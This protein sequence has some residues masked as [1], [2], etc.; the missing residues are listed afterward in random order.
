MLSNTF[1]TIVTNATAEIQF[2]RSVLTFEGVKSDAIFAYPPPLNVLA[3]LIMLPL[4]FTMTPRWFHKTN[5]A[6][7]RTFNA[8]LLLLISFLEGQSL[9]TDY[10]AKGF[11]SHK[12]ALTLGKKSNTL[13][14]WGFA[15]FSVHG[16]IQAVFDAEPPSDTPEEI[17]DTQTQ[18]P[19]DYRKPS[20]N[21]R[22]GGGQVISN[23]K[24]KENQDSGLMAKSLGTKQLREMMEEAVDGADTRR[25]LEE[26]ELRS[27]RIESLLVKLADKGAV[28]EEME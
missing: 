24:K 4:K 7:V 2:R 11:I 17:D 25:R 3:L 21:V 19:I 27:K 10:S 23:S 12:A 18:G 15:R 9:W 8:P 13:A 28:S 14:F 26:L 16:D 20:D 22:E 6:V 5:V 1:S